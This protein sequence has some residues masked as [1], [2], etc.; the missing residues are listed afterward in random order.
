MLRYVIRRMLFSIP[1]L[2]VSSVLVF[3]VVR[4]NG[5]FTATLRANPRARPEDIQRVKE[6]LGL[7]RSGPEQYLGWLTHFVQGDWGE[8][9]LTGNSVAK[10]IRDAFWNTMV[11]GLVATVLSLVLGIGIGVYSALR[12]YSAFDHVA[13]T[14]AFIGLS[15]PNFWFALMLQLLFGYYLTRWFNLSDPV[16]Y[17]T[18]MKAPGTQGVD[19]MDRVRHII[20][21]AFV[22]TVQVVAIYSRFVRSSMLEVM[23][24]DFL[25][26]ARAKGLRERRV[27]TRHAIR[28]A[29]IPLVTQVAID[30]GLLAGGLIITESI[31]Q[32][33]GMGRFFIVA[34]GNGDYPQMLPW[35]MVV[36]AFVIV[37]NLLADITY[38]V[39][40]PRI[41][42]T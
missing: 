6:A 22:V 23:H 8:S 14:G 17:T 12:Q 5:D 3:V 36:V 1:V 4:A 42:Y 31:F 37:F 41:R 33:P 21:P 27:I 26:T 29:L 38:A 25:R 9:L 16:L 34:V 40:D 11:L 20:L 39:L 30:T 7:D 35:V 28:N 32:W 13:T 15:M 18:G 2:L 24:S 19:I 10:D